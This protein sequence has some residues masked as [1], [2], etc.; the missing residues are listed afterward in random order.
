MI[1]DKCHPP[2]TGVL[3]LN[4]SEIVACGDR[5][6]VVSSTYSIHGHWK[7]GGAQPLLTSKWRGSSPPYFS[8]PEV[9]KMFLLSNIIDQVYISRMTHRANT[10]STLPQ[11]SELY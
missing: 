6:V 10:G 4:A 3:W 5:S 9:I 8:T 1:G 7:Y 11:G 2:L